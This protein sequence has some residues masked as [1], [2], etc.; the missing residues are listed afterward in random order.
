MH[1]VNTECCRALAVRVFHRFLVARCVTEEERTSS[2]IADREMV[3][4]RWLECKAFQLAVGERLFPFPICS[5]IIPPLFMDGRKVKR[6][7][8]SSKPDTRQRTLRRQIFYESPRI[9]V[10]SSTNDGEALMVDRLMSAVFLV[11]LQL[12][13]SGT[14][15][16]L[17]P[18]IFSPF[19]SC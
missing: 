18:F 2:S 16:F 15:C 3:K 6:S 1:I 11:A 13:S 10:P 5:V 4:F 9:K 12:R 8:N 14:R 17:A 19:M 7:A